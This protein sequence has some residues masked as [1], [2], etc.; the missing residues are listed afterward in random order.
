MRRSRLTTLI[1]VLLLLAAACWWA[2]LNRDRIAP[3]LVNPLL[4]G[5]QVESIRGLDPGFGAMSLEQI[6]LTLES[7]SKIAL[8]DIHLQRPFDLLFGARVNRSHLTIAEVGYLPAPQIAAAPAPVPA[9]E[10]TSAARQA[11]EPAQAGAQPGAEA[12]RLGELLELLQRYLPEHIRIPDLRWLGGPIERGQLTLDRD[13]KS[14]SVEL[15]LASE[16]HQLQLQLRHLDREPEVQVTLLADTERAATLS[17]QLKRLDTENW[18]AQLQLQ[19][20]L[21]QLRRLPLPQAVSE[22]VANASGSADARLAMQLPDRLLHLDEYRNIL[23]ELSADRATLALPEPLLGAPLEL[24]FSTPGVATV[25]FASLS[26]FR[27]RDIAGGGHL[28]LSTASGDTPLLSADIDTRVSGAQPVIS[29]AGEIRFAALEPLLQAE[30]WQ[31][32]AGGL[33]LT[34]P[35]GS[36]SFRGTAKL[37]PLGQMTAGSAPTVKDLEFSLLPETRLGLTAATGDSDIPVLEQL[38]WPRAIATLALNEPLTVS[39]AQWPGSISL[40]APALELRLR[41]DGDDAPISA[42]ISALECRIDTDRTCRLDLEA[43]AD[44]L[45][46]PAQELEGEQVS[47][48]SHLEVGIQQQQTDLTLADMAIAAGNLR[49]QAWKL[50]TV[51]IRSPEVHCSL[52]ASGIDCSADS[53]TTT[54]D[55][56]STDGLATSGTVDLQA[57]SLSTADSGVQLEARYS[58]DDIHA[59][60][61][62]QY[63]FDASIRGR[64]KLAGD[65]LRGEGTLQA[66][67][68]RAEADWHHLLESGRGSAS[69]DIPSV[70]FSREAPLSDSISGLPADLVAGSIGASG[71]ISWPLGSAKGDRLSLTL[72]RLAATYGDMFAVDASGTLAAEQRDGLWVTGSPQPLTVGSVDVGVAIDDIRFALS[73]D[74]Q[75]NLELIDLRAEL[76]GGTLRSPQLTWNLNGEMRRSEARLDGISLE[77]LADEMEAENFAAS[78]ILDLR[79]PLLTD[80]DGVTVEQGRVEARPPGG[81][82]RYYGAF[83][84]S[85]LSGNPQLKL[86]AGALE[87]YNYRELSGTLEYPPSG[88]MQMQLKLVGRSDSVAEDRDLVINLN[89]ENNIPDM[90]RSLQASRDLT[91][92]LEKAV[93]EQ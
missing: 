75:R 66:G 55:G 14:G 53:I 24:V 6:T 54:T 52:A 93:S 82:L 3:N 16:Q 51:S 92:A 89:L 33:Q 70:E 43:G 35:E 46:L 28:T 71:Q 58:S 91:G 36:G 64:F 74:R 78:G 23:V 40:A 22:A 44:R 26:P 17:G 48:S 20:A 79:I 56:A 32:L 83:S 15:H 42:Q 7:G 69:F 38:G 63:A 8:R 34:S 87:D 49:R 73:L 4:E 30:R 18:T 2:W 50:E 10:T 12:L 80:A 57:L 45:A 88:D 31:S 11:A 25:T 21:G 61:L 68:L 9:G 90:L 29:L 76:L 41:P 62:E 85:M 5:S 81:R 65:T 1:A 47:L 39:A 37:Q 13:H 72:D 60:V 67:A 86:I 19:L 84:P 59:R 77:Q 27:P